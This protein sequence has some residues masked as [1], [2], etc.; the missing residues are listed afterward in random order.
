MNRHVKIVL[1]G[2]LF[3]WYFS[4]QTHTIEAKEKD[5]ADK[6][7]LE[8]QKPNF[9]YILCDDLG[10]G[11]VRIFNPKRC[12]IATEHMDKLAKQGMIFTDAH[13]GSA[14]CT[15]TRYGILTG[16]YSW[17]SRLQSGVL[18][19]TD[20]P[21]I[22]TSRLTVAKFLQQNG[23]HTACMGKWHLG[24]DWA[25]KPMSKQDQKT[26]N[27]KGKIEKKGK[28]PPRDASWN[29]DYTKPI[30][31]GPTSLGFDYFFGISASL[32]MPPYV[33]IGND[34]VTSLPTVEKTYIRKGAASADFE[35]IDVLPKL[36]E[37]AI[38]YIQERS[39]ESKKG[40]PFFLYLAFASPHT[41]IVP[42]KSFQG[43]SNLSPYGDF[44]MQTD[45]SIGKILD[46]LDKTGLS[47][48]TIVI[49]TSDNG[50]SP[51]ANVN[52]LEKLGHFASGDLRGYKADIW[53]GGHRMPFIVRWPGK[54]KSGTSCSQTI[55]HT[56]FFATCADILQKKLPDNAAEDSF[57]L[58]PLWLG[59]Q[60]KISRAAVIHH[61]ISGVFSIR[62]GDDKLILC[63][64]SG[65]W[66]Q[67][68]DKKALQDHL[69]SAQLYNMKDDI[70][71]Q[72]NLA[73]DQQQT[74]D[75]LTKL[76]EEYIHNG[77]SNSG[78]PQ[79]ND[80]MIKIWKSR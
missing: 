74:I 64:G 79:Q 52:Q 6:I 50:C 33:F 68:N 15:P 43:K 51:W 24:L 14:V 37:K 28:Q 57:S 7:V 80:A 29:I 27:N 72:K 34:K 58:L 62:Q 41:P 54:I 8:N 16:R 10:Y 78:P 42:A 47:D 1:A 38:T 76:L 32:D 71:E 19:G 55:C 69:P 4:G 25:K 18:S 60:K 40:K 13:S 44:V 70:G 56:D 20:S 9:L 12:K 53:D 3:L 75:R 61:S 46:C 17:R 22:P 35:A 21:L 59:K 36:T 77:R 39:D 2:L 49:L 11:D 5:S 30:A 66:S 63:P 65:G 26:D 31:N 48:N 73:K 23:Y 45:D 67:P